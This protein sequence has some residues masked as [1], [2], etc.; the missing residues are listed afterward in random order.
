MRIQVITDAWYPQVNGVVRTLT[1]IGRELEHLGHTVG[2]IT[3]DR[4]RNLPC[5]SYPEIRLALAS[6]AAVGRRI[7]A[8]AP[9][10]LHIATEGP[11]GMAARRFALRRMI[12]FTTSF[13]TRFPE[14]VHA[15]IRLPVAWSYAWLRKFHAPARAVMVATETMRRDLGHYGFE[16]L[17]IWS[18]GVDMTQFQ[19]G[20]KSFPEDRRPILLYVGRVAVEK[21]VGD[22]LRLD[23]SG[24]KY[25]VGDGPQLK[26]LKRLYPAVRFVGAKY[27][28]ELARYYSGADVLVFPSRTDT[29]GNVILEALAS[30][31]PVAA[32]PCPGPN[33]IIADHPVGALD[34]DLG[35]AVRRALEASPETCRAFAHGYS[36]RASA[37][38]FLGN[39]SPF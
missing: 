33:D 36:W 31:V 5:P 30:G 38:Q 27:G 8:F 6:P 39:L 22:F 20:P 7:E 26:A 19:P 13:H 3:P 18:R 16:R 10:A 9:Q 24:T 32:Y 15:R 25:V 17:V 29:F 14:Y 37:E 11:L 28:D 34:E 35:R 12:P 4:F 2:F 23:A 1:N 21:N